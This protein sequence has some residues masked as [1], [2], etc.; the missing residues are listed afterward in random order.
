M[1]IPRSP[2]VFRADSDE[3]RKCFA[4]NITDDDIH[5]GVEVFAVNLGLERDS[6]V[7]VQPN[8][9]HVSILNDDGM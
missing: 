4:V 5:E 9:T 2:V 6:R 7:I 1:E 8:V 3:R